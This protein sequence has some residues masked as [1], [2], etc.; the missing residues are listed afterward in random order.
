M[1]AI[2]KIKLLINLVIFLLSFTSAPVEAETS[3]GERREKVGF[4]RMA[5][6]LGSA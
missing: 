3:K 2:N 1:M 6:P 5:I 4:D